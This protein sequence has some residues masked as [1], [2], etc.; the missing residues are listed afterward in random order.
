MIRV[1]TRVIASTN[2]D[3]AA[4]LSRGECREDLYYRLN[5]IEIRIPPLRERKEEIPGL[6]AWFLARFNEQYSRVR[7]NRSEAA[8]RLRV[9]YKTL[10]NKVTDGETRIAYP[11][12]TNRATGSAS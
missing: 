8:R 1:D 4:A 9:S 11:G 12:A 10:L 7:W 6:T 3:L 5:V 2:L